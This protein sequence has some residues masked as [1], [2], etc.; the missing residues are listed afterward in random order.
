LPCISF[1]LQTTPEHGKGQEVAVRLY[2]VFL[3]CAWVQGK[4]YVVLDG[5]II[6]FKFNVTSTGKK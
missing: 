2:R 3:W 5:D 1:W 4:N 6:L